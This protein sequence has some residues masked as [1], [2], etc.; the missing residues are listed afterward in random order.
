[1]KGKEERKGDMKEADKK[2][3][4]KAMKAKKDE[5]ERKKEQEE[6]V[7]GWSGGDLAPLTSR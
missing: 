2:K 3:E 5:E 7:A 1:M 4:D 6:A